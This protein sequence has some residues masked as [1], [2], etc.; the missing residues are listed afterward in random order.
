MNDNL[1]EYDVFDK[2]VEAEIAMAHVNT[3]R[4][5]IYAR[6]QEIEAAQ[7]DEAKRLQQK[8]HDL[9]AILQR[10]KVYD[11]DAVRAVRDFW[12]PLTKDET[13]FWILINGDHPSTRPSF[14]SEKPST[15][16]SE[17]TFVDW[18]WR[19]AVL[20]PWPRREAFAVLKPEGPWEKVDEL[21]VAETGGVLTEEAWRAVFENKFG[22]LDLSTLPHLGKGDGL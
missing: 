21:D 12:G 1:T 17:L 14:F 16:S 4:A 11:D 5:M 8:A 15:D 19:P 6:I 7:S 22:E 18:D 13:T 2:I 10:I 9:Y 20:T 3:A